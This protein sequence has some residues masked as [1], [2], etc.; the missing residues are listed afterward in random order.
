M[1]QLCG[2]LDLEFLAAFPM[3]Q[4]TDM[5]LTFEDLIHKNGTPIGL[6]SDNATPDPALPLYGAVLSV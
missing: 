5:L 3:T 1:V 4:E 6:M 2:S